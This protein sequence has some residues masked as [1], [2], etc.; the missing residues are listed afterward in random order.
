MNTTTLV[1]LEPT[2]DTSVTAVADTLTQAVA[3]ANTIDDIKRLDARISAIVTLAEKA[4]AKIPVLNK[5]VAVRLRAQRKMG[6]LFSRI[7]RSD[8]GRPR[9]NSTPRETSYQSA[10][11]RT[12]TSPATAQR[13]QKAATVP[14]DLFEVWVQGM[15]AGWMEISLT[16]LCKLADEIELGFESAIV[17]RVHPN[18]D[19]PD[20][21][22]AHVR[23]RHTAEG[24]RA[25]SHARLHVARFK[26]IQREFPTVTPE[27]LLAP[28][29]LLM[30]PERRMRFRHNALR[31]MEWL[32]C[33]ETTTAIE[34][35][36]HEKAVEA[37][38][39]M[40]GTTI[41]GIPPRDVHALAPDWQ[42]AT[43]HPI[44]PS[45]PGR[46]V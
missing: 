46:F 3:H 9:E 13:Y 17:Y 2:S 21:Q 29:Y 37:T 15:T 32:G 27:Q 25:A 24:R 16:A 35:A 8:G 11:F 33:D 42:P 12:G 4:R 23:R 7:A 19:D 6:V 44:V 5:I 20:V 34:W 10:C 14:D 1:R 31:L 39:E 45:G 40:R 28:V 36:V 38:R 26:Q 18:R 41:W 30:A 22:S 43:P